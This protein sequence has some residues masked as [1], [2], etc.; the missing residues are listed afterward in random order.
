MFAVDDVV[1][2]HFPALEG[3][4]W[5]RR[6]VSMVL[7]RLLHER[8]FQ[9]FG[10]E[11]PHLRGLDFVE[12]VLEYFDFSFSVRDSE[13]E[14]IPA[15]GRVVIIANH[16]IGSLDGLALIKLV[17][18]VRPDVKVVSNQLLMAI[19]ALH[20]LLLPVNNMGG[21]SAKDKL[22]NIHKHLVA[23][24]ALIIFPAGEVS[25]LRPQGVRDTRWQDGFLRIARLSRSPVL[26]VFL[27]G[28]NSSVF[29]SLS[30]LYKPLSTL[31]LVTEMFKQRARHLPVRIGEMIPVDAW[32][33]QPISLKQQ[34][35]LFKKHLY[36]I[37]R[38]AEPVFRTQPAI[39]PP[40]NRRELRSAV[41]HCE[42]LGV[43]V[44]GKQIYLYRHEDSSPVMREIGR[45]R[46]VSFRAV[47]EGTHKRRDI[48]VFDSHYFHLLLWDPEE[49]EIVGA[50]RLGDARRLHTSDAGLYSAR[51]FEYDAKMTEFFDQGLELGRGFV[52]PRYWGK[53]SLDYL[54]IGIG[55]FLRR[56]PG[57]RYLFGPV[58]ISG[59]MPETARSLLIAFYRHYFSASA[60]L[61]RACHPYPGARGLPACFVGDNYDQD[62]L[63]LRYMLADLGVAIPT[64]Y[65]QYTELCEPGGASFLAFGIDESFGH[66]VDGLI[67]VD[68]Q[69]MRPHKHKRYLM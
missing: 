56:Y 3:K 57:Y 64:L 36:R 16:P 34:I 26:P 44:D 30:M 69:R 13:R 2:A 66:C 14:R 58:S 4:P 46:E 8:E 45:L 33:D 32:H 24:G 28:K 25:R 41:Q 43:S 49:L 6:P 10:A 60:G 42:S 22:R 18:E 61:A 5:L 20:P 54:W 47:G 1:S 12:Q 63:K 35:K 7:R 65:K 21:G 31:L 17:S 50:Y 11:Y 62:L 68:T 27:D 15:Q 9:D 52:Q 29:Y 51:L 53:R 19:E 59:A 48:D 39:A 55:A 40:E 38:D 23:E 37:G 67:L